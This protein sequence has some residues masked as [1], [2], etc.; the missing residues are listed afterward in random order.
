MKLLAT[1]LFVIHAS[2]ASA[3]PDSDS[4]IQALISALDQLRTTGKVPALGLVLLD[5]RAPLVIRTL[6]A[7][8]PDTPFR[9]GSI[10]KSFTALSALQLV[11]DGAVKLTEP[12]RPLLGPGFYVNKFANEQPLQLNQLLELSAGFAELS[13]A[14]FSDN[15]PLPLLQA[16]TRN[17]DQRASLWPPG[18]QHSY[19]NVAPGLSALVI[20]RRSGMTF[21]EFLT[22]RVLN[23]LGMHHASLDPVPGLPGGL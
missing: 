7:A 15:Q 17:Q 19:S 22:A 1:L 16:L 4:D 18:L 11:D 20:E 9:W 10:T 21:E 13:G 2:A 5:K 12:V 6:G 8:Q 23:R 14:E 3:A